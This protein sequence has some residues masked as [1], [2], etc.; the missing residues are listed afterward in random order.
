MQTGS[1]CFP[2]AEQH[3]YQFPALC[4]MASDG[5]SAIFAAV[6]G[7]DIDPQLLRLDMR[8]LTFAGQLTRDDLQPILAPDVDLPAGM[9]PILNLGLL[10]W[11]GGEYAVHPWKIFR[12]TTLP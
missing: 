8:T 7:D 6:I 12:V 5:S 3:P 11:D 1:V 10:F 9:Q 2:L 4:G